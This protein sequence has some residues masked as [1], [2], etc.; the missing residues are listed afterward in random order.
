MNRKIASES[1]SLSLKPDR[2]SGVKAFFG[3]LSVFIAVLSFALS[4]CANEDSYLFRNS[5]YSTDHLTQIQLQSYL[6][7]QPTMP[8]L[9]LSGYEYAVSEGYIIDDN[10]FLPVVYPAAAQPKKMTFDKN[11]VNSDRLVHEKEIA[12]IHKLMKAQIDEGYQSAIQSEIIKTVQKVENELPVQNSSFGVVHDQRSGKIVGILRSYEAYINQQ[13]KVVLP[14]FEILR[15]RKLLTDAEEKEL[16]K[17][18]GSP[19]GGLKT[20]KSMI[21]VGQFYIDGNLA[22]AERLEVKRQLWAW[23]TAVILEK[24]QPE[25]VVA[26]VSKNVLARKYKQEYGF[27]QTAIEKSFLEK[28]ETIT[29]KV[30]TVSAVQMKQHLINII[31]PKTINACHLLFHL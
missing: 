5:I 21:E 10:S 6:Q 24:G 30:L 1:S 23:F 27:D 12:E 2:Q 20:T 26:H 17:S 28:G 3:T 16:L 8:F 4:V 31:A 15:Q 7:A 18:V 9:T 14:S 29:E 25:T 11:G 19:S 22:P 13:N